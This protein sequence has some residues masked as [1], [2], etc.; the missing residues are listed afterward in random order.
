[1]SENSKLQQWAP[2]V[3]RVGLVALFLWFG[4]S[5]LMNPADWVAWVPPSAISLAPANTIVLV[6]GVFEVILGAALAVGFF[7]RWAALLLALH[8]FAIA[9]EIGYNDIGVRDFALGVATLALFFYGADEYTLDAR[10]RRGS[11][12][13][14]AYEG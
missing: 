6:N 9:F 12:T 8:L 5:Q 7:T 4:I 10:M 13:M 11:A 2:L 3:L 14:N 1:M